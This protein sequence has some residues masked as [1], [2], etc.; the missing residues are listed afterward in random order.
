MQH[1]FC[2]ISKIEAL[3][4]GKNLHVYPRVYKG[5]ERAAY[6]R[7]EEGVGKTF[8]LMPGSCRREVKGPDRRIM[9][10]KGI[11]IQSVQTMSVATSALSLVEVEILHDRPR[12]LDLLSLLL[13]PIDENSGKSRKELGGRVQPPVQTNSNTLAGAKGSSKQ[14]A[15]LQDGHDLRCEGKAFLPECFRMDRQ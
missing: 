8:K 4:G 13:L 6:G 3:Q 11:G 1:T 5:N 7:L 15:Y 2:T 14:L 10:R 9:K 12:A